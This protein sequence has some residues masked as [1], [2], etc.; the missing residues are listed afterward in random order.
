MGHGLNIMPTAVDDSGTL[1]G[2]EGVKKRL[3]GH[4]EEQSFNLCLESSSYVIYVSCTSGVTVIRWA[5]R[6]KSL[7]LFVSN[8]VMPRAIMVA[9]RCVS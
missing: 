3:A 9:T 4:R 6:A 2:G 7:G 1:R 5:K 8:S